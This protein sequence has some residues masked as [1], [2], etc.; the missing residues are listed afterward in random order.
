M[1]KPA[2]IIATAMKSMSENQQKENEQ[3][4][5]VA[6]DAFTRAR[7]AHMAAMKKLY[8][9]RRPFVAVNRSGSP[10]WMKAL[11]RSRAGAAGFAACAATL[12]PK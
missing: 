8:T 4:V 9:S 10:Q 6:L 5:A 12:P 1:I 2:E 3:R 11:R 7:D